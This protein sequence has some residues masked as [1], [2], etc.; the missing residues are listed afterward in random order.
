MDRHGGQAKRYQISEVSQ[1]VG[2]SQK[3]I[4]DYEKAGFVKPTRAP[5]TNNRIYVEADIKRLIRIKELIH[6]YGFTLTCLRYFF[7]S[8]PCWTIFQCKDKASCS[9]YQNPHKTCY[10]ATP[11]GEA[12][13]S[14]KCNRCPVYMNRNA[15][16]ITLLEQN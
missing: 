6:E 16:R 7:A 5:R 9:A 13:M 12:S 15:K 4:R 11:G 10:E 2:L 1:R 14:R 3:R 8:A